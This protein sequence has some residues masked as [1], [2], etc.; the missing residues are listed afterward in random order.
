MVP[1]AVVVATKS[2][3][4]SQIHVNYQNKRIGK[5][6]E[7]ENTAWKAC[8][9]ISNISLNSCLISVGIETSVCNV[10]GV[11]F[12]TLP[13]ALEYAFSS[14]CLHHHGWLER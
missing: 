9:H 1:N 11:I 14:H 2:K 3:A 10:R 12:R 4:I 13:H 7:L 6:S 5:H 8:S